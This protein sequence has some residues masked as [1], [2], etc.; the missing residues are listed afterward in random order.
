MGGG[1]FK[2]PLVHR[3]LGLQQ[4]GG[5]VHLPLMFVLS[6]VLGSICSRH[7]PPRGIQSWWF[8]PQEFRPPL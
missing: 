7:A 6:P 4:L 2:L 5:K 8:Q 1:E 3:P